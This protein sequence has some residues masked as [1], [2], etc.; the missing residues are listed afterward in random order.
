MWVIMSLGAKVYSD[1]FLRGRSWTDDKGIIT[2][3]IELS[4]YM[5]VISET[6]N[7]SPFSISQLVSISPI[8]VE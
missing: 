1:G 8:G 3:D 4:R 7:V 5:L 6:V 2:W